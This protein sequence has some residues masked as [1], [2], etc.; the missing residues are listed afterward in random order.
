MI[1][2][3]ISPDKESITIVRR[4][5]AE[6][7]FLQKWL[8]YENP[9]SWVPILRS[10]RSPFSVPL[11][12]SRQVIQEECLRLNAFIRALTNHPTFAN[13]E[14][15]WEFLLVQ[16]M[17]QQQSIERCRRKL[18]SK[19]ELQ[20]EDITVYNSP[21]LDLIDVFFNHAR[22]ETQVLQFQL[23]R[24]ARFLLRLENKSLDYTSAYRIL[25]SKLDAVEFFKP[26]RQV[27]KPDFELAYSVADQ[28]LK[29]LVLAMTSTASTSDVVIGALTQPLSLIQQLKAQ[30]LSLIR[31]RATLDKLSN[32]GSWPLGMFEDKRLRDIKQT[33]DSIYITQ[34]EIQRLSTDIKYSHITL[35]TELGGF[36]RSQEHELFHAIKEFAETKLQ[37]ERE[38]LQRLTRLQ[39]KF[40]TVNFA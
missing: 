38:R 34:N 21:D 26:L 37:A 6:F 9:Y 15:L 8:A 40:L 10:L 11:K 7:L 19:R 20:F 39:R 24:L 1:L 13:H 33:E 36:H 12:P 31:A 14:L 32:R 35:A 18:E 28:S 22:N 17:S 23:Q 5:F 27:L 25:E 2:S 16:D 29:K 30:E 4:S 3:G